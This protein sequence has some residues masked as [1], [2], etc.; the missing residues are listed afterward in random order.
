MLEIAIVG[1]PGVRRCG[2]L[3][4]MQDHRVGAGVCKRFGRGGGDIG[5]GG[6][7]L[8]SEYYQR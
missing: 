7:V 8:I 4:E 5:V 6:L 1:A 2:C 3:D